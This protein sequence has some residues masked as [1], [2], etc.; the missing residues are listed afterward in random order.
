[1]QH[2][3]LLLW[4]KC[5]DSISFQQV[6]LGVSFESLI[7]FCTVD[8]DVSVFHKVC[9][10]AERH[11]DQV[12]RKDTRKLTG[13]G[14]RSYRTINKQGNVAPKGKQGETQWTNK[15]CISATDRDGLR[16]SYRALFSQFVLGIDKQVTLHMSSQTS[17]QFSTPM[18]KGGRCHAGWV[19][20]FS[21]SQ[22][23]LWAL[24]NTLVGSPNSSP[25]ISSQ[26]WRP[27]AYLPSNSLSAD[28]LAHSGSRILCFLC[29][30]LFLP[31][32]LVMNSGLSGYLHPGHL[33]SFTL[34]TCLPSRLPRLGLLDI[35]RSRMLTQPPV[36]VPLPRHSPPTFKISHLVLGYLVHPHP[37]FL[38]LANR[39]LFPFQKTYACVSSLPW[40]VSALLS[41]TNISLWDFFLCFASQ[42]CLILPLW[43]LVI[44]KILP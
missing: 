6:E 10:E 1:M 38:F 26:C 42:P 24:I 3:S 34:L 39:S 43:V 20:V 36:A 35:P 14:N 12:W 41:H 33:L 9:R 18:K 13:K 21:H 22:P 5:D 44:G 17:Q 27:A 31:V 16:L 4:H 32:P 29:R 40:I 37:G 30:V 25:A 15:L 19:A 28:Q 2:L 23:R 11:S 8:S 7:R